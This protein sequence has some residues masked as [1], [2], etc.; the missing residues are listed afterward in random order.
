MYLNT[1]YFPLLMAKWMASLEE[2]ILCK[3]RRNTCSQDS[4][5]LQ[6]LVSPDELTWPGRCM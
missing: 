6:I 4:L 5:D 3:W 2:S 1:Q